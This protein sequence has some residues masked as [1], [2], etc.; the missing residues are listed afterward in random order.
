MHFSSSRIRISTLRSLN[1]LPE[2]NEPDH[3]TKE[4]NFPVYTINA[5]EETL[6]P[7]HF[8]PIS[9]VLQ[10]HHLMVLGVPFQKKEESDW[11]SY[12]RKSAAVM[13]HSLKQSLCGVPHFR[14]A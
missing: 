3:L 5:E 7:E 10:R 4:F 9:V 11:K 13:V 12:N 2:P 14:P 8:Y 1:L 6:H